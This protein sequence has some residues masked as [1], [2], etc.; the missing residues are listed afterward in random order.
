MTLKQNV[1]LL[2][3]SVLLAS[4][5]ALVVLGMVTTVASAQEGQNNSTSTNSTSDTISST[6][7]QTIDQNTRITN[8][9]YSD[10]EFVLLVAADSPTRMTI[11]QSIDTRD[12]DSGTGTILRRSLSS[13]ENRIV[14]NTHGSSS[15]PAL[16]ITTPQ[17]IENEEYTYVKADSPS[18]LIPQ[19]PY[20]GSDVQAA[21]VGGALS[22]AVMVL[23]RGAQAKVGSYSGGTRLA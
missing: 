3:V 20:S 23:F 6:T 17:S 1:V 22:V 9:S 18:N 19:G 12:A 11:T 10:G 2:L 5:C 13:G 14:V 7:V 21:G 15:S 4:L 16:F 8:W